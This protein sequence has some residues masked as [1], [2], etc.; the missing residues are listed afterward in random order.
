[1]FLLETLGRGGKADVGGGGAGNQEGTQ[2][3]REKG[4][5]PTKK[6]EIKNPRTNKTQLEK[7]K[8]VE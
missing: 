6:P 7:K 1:M 4:P 2:H 8:N 5:A 3:R